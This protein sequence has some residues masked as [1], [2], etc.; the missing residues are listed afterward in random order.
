MK[1]LGIDYGTV[2]IG[3]AMSDPLGIMASPHMTLDA[4]TALE[5]IAKITA[6]ERVGKIILGYPK[7]MNNTIGP[8][9]L[10]V[11]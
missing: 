3:L 1:V 7:N 4:D 11:E 9:A 8:A 2:R 6:Q 5:K 10:A